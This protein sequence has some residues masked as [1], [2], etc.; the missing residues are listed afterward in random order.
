[1]KKFLVLAPFL[2]VFGC[3]CASVPTSGSSNCALGT[4]G[5]ACAN[6]CNALGGKYTAGGSC[7]DACTNEVKKE[8]L[9]DATTCCTST[10]RDWCQDLC[11]E[12][13]YTPMDECMNDCVI[14]YED[15][16]VSPDSCY[17]PI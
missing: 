17:I 11:S 14:Q 15:F 1:M 12:N 13:T 4:Y 2:L 9:G 3:C 7:F 16:G 8:G 6:V 5:E 10:F